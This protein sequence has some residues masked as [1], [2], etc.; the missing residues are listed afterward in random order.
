MNNSIRENFVFF[1]I[2]IKSYFD[3]GPKN[4]LKSKLK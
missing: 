3:Y 2:F 4:H 1:L